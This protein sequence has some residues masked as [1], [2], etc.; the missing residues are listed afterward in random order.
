MSFKDAIQEYVNLDYEELLCLA[1]D[2]LANLIPVFS[3]IAD[4]GDGAGYIVPFICASVA[5]DGKLSRLESRFV[6][7]FVDGQF[8][9][10][11]VFDMVQEH[12]NAATFD[13]VDEI[14]D[15]CPVELQT[16]LMCLCL[17]ICA[18]DETVNRDETA[19]LNRLFN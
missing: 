13:F 9:E 12:Y 11:E 3:E 4:D 18:V 7:D 14:F 5:V 10:D 6:S 8:S 17:C 15:N 2:S 1:K 19:F 16:D